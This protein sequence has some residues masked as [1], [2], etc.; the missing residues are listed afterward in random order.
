MHHVSPS[1]GQ[2]PVFLP[3]P[4]F[5]LCQ[6]SATSIICKDIGNHSFELH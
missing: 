6:S 4:C 3:L 5:L 2:I 1:M